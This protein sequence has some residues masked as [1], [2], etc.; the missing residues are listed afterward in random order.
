VAKQL[1]EGEP[2]IAV[3][4]QRGGGLRISVWLMRADEHEIVARRLQEIFKV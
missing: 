4:G 3:S 2:S 1:L